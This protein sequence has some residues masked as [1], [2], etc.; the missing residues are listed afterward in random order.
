MHL[1]LYNFQALMLYNL[2]VLT[3]IIG[4][5]DFLINESDFYKA[6]FE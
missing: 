5:E 1:L 3:D 2:S 4:W 6:V